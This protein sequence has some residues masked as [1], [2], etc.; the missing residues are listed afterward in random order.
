MHAVAVGPGGRIYALDRS[1]G[2]VNIFKTTAD[3]AKLEFVEAWPGFSLPLDIIVND[4]A[5]WVADL[6]P[7]RFTK[8]DF[9]GKHLYTW[10]VSNEM[11]DGQLEVHAFSVDA[12][13]NLYMGDNQH[14]RTQKLTPKRDADP[15]LIIKRQ[16]KAQ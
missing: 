3:P 16:W 10:M 9:S 14:G 7:L 13:L 11:P 15:A 8:L 12:E 5:V 1:G 6:S 4:D 2:R